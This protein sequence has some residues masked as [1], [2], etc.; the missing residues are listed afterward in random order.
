MHRTVAPVAVSP[1]A[2]LESPSLF[3]QEATEDSAPP[4][5]EIK[6]LLTEEQ[7][8]AVE[9]RVRGRLSLDPH[10]DPTLGGAYRITSLYTDTA[11]FDVFRRAGE[12]A[13]SKFRVRRYGHNGPVYVERK[14]K[15]GAKVRKSRVS[16]P[17]ADLAILAAPV[18]P[19]SWAG[20]WFHH[21]LMRRKLAPV[22][23]ISYERMAYL[24]TADGGTVR[25]TFD[26][27]VRG[28]LAAG[29][30]VV[31]V[32]KSRELLPKQV[33]CEFKYRAAM[34]L[35]FKELVESLGLN[36][37]PCSKYR[38]FVETA[39]IVPKMTGAER[40]GEDDV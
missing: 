22:C 3:R 27:T 5:Y 38:R 29:W 12:F 36:P 7:A 6:F 18:T 37:Q 33:I 21:E 30:D 16:V 35:L 25:L 40:G 8:R 31:P 23:R 2:A 24:G 11:Q 32:V 1:G 34:P 26:R 17:T 20:G 13:R 19:S 9:D 4:A 15:N 14:D 28:E 39:G 10:A